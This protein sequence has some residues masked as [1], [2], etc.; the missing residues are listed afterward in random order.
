V[1]LTTAV[2]INPSKATD[3]DAERDAICAA[4]A[5]VGCPDPMWLETTVEDPGCR[6]A[7]T[8]AEAGAERERCTRHLE[9]CLATTVDIH[10][11]TI[12]PREVDGDTIEPGDRLTVTMRPKC[13]WICAP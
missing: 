7:R 1:P 2:V 10:S 9:T 13:L 8:A 5:A 11:T 4:L 3:P 6:Q 12:Q